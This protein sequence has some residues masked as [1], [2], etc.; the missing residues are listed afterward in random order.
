MF[1]LHLVIFIWLLL[2]VVFLSSWACK[3]AGWCCCLCLVACEPSVCAACLC[4]AC[5]AWNSHQY[6]NVGVYFS[7]CCTQIAEISD[8]GRGRLLSNQVVAVDVAACPF[9]PHLLHEL[10][11]ILKAR[12]LVGRH[13]SAGLLLCATPSAHAVTNYCI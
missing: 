12:L 3:V 7:L 10:L 2:P 13:L 4:L 9:V 11:V 1:S 5:K 8:L 6:D